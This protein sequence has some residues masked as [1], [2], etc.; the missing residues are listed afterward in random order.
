MATIL[1]VDDREDERHYLQVLFQHSGH[2][3][4]VAENGQD[5]IVAMSASIPDLVVTDI[6]MPTMDGFEFI[7]RM[8]ERS[9]TRNIPVILYTAAYDDWATQAL[10]AEWTGATILSK[11]SEPE[12]ILRAINKILREPSLQQGALGEEFRTAH[13]ELVT[14]KLHQKMDA[15]E[16]TN[17]R[18]AQSEERLRLALAGA[19]MGT[20]DFNPITGE[21][22]WDE[23]CK[24]AFGLSPDAKVNYDIFLAGLHPNDREHTDSAVKSALDPAGSGEYDIEYRTVGLEDGLERYVHAQG[25]ASFGNVENERSA[26]RFVGIV[27]DI[28]TRKRAEEALHR[29]N[30]NLRQFAY[31]A[32]HDLQEPLRNVSILLGL[33]KRTYQGAS[34]SGTPAYKVDPDPEQLIDQSTASAQHMVSMVRDLLAF[35]TIGDHEQGQNNLVDA[36]KVLERVLKSLDPSISESGA[37]ITCGP[38]PKVRISATHLLQLL[39]NLIGNAL[40]YRK[41]GQI[42]SIEISA[43]HQGAEWIFSVAD[44]GIG[45]DPIYGER[46]FG[47]FKRLHQRHEYP[48]TGIGLA[49]CSRIV[50]AYGGR[51]WAEGQSG[52]G[53]IFRFTLPAEQR[54]LE[55]PATERPTKILVV[56]DNPVDVRM[57]RRA[58]QREKTW[59]TEI[60]VAE[61]GEA[62]I[63]YLKRQGPFV[64]ASRPDVVILD[65][66]LPKRDG[67][68]VL[69]MIRTTDNLRDLPV[70]VFSSS[71][72]AV[73]EQRVH[74]A[75]VTADQYM[76]KPSEAEDFL[77]LGAV[78]RCFCYEV[79]S[80]FSKPITT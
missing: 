66:N 76:R 44:N 17:A 8:R 77:A 2:Q 60:A 43:V 54:E 11:P 79:D 15:L 33:L 46:I 74:A 3:V 67:T 53:A 12:V 52:T 69:R 9:E 32:A 29:A 68:E 56:E 37:Q 72:E 10:A 13:L 75:N 61:D 39:Q 50:S 30:E 34:E 31:A 55:Q 38:L 18:L 6:L 4:T 80:R 27:Q 26:I 41:Q 58:L 47:I 23:R 59:L 73:I 36:D 24:A 63:H 71:P 48:G 14:T 57:I 5:A 42:P 19:S 16:S 7:R 62:A 64:R 65:L 22:H 49:I 21:L 70:F 25:R 78:L 40:K 28:T 20:W 1:L 35:A 45:F 51:I